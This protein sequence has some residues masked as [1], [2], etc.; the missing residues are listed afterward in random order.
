M[1]PTMSELAALARLYH[2]SLSALL[3]GLP[4]RPTI[5]WCRPNDGAPPGKES[6]A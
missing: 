5:L 4:P 6:E 3:E 1:D 2:V